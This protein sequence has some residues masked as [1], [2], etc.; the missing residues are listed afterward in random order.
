MQ[1]LWRQ[2]ELLLK[3]AWCMLFV[4][5]PLFTTGAGCAEEE[6]KLPPP[7]H[8]GSRV[9]VNEDMVV[10]IMD[11]NDPERYNRGVRF[12][13]LATVLRVEIGEDEYLY[14]PVEHDPMTRNAGLAT[15][16]DIWHIPDT[17]EEAGLHEGFVKIGVGVLE[18]AVEKYRFSN[19]YPAIE[20]APTTVEWG[21]A[22]AK[23]KQTCAGVRG[24]AYDLEAE[25]TVQPTTV[26]INWKLTNTGTR[27]ITTEQYVHNWFAFNHA[28]VGPNYIVSFPYDITPD[29]ETIKPEQEHVGRSI[30]YLE[31]I[32][33]TVE[34]KIP[35]P[36]EPGIKNDAMTRNTENGLWILSEVSVPGDRTVIHAKKDYVCPEMFIM[37]ELDPGESKSWT[38]TY[39]F[40]KS[41]PTPKAGK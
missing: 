28:P 5:L 31:E 25:V 40:G 10:E 34:I 3:V 41:H 16:F 32:P 21:E 20:L 26:A 18:K 29:P 39:E 37:I 36:E 15:E 38:R 27:K 11:P 8:K 19:P 12:T 30:K 22:S 24:Y 23:F 1:K 4:L 35:F 6:N 17:H 33:G 2:K 9:L 13:P 7:V 14:N